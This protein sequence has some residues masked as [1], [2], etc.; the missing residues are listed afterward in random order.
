MGLGKNYKKVEVRI[1]GRKKLVSHIVWEENNPREII[2]FCDVI[3]HIDG[4]PEKNEIKNLKKMSRSSHVKYHHE[5]NKQK[6]IIAS[7]H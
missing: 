3:H 7:Y 1:D 4:N 6:V 2:G 5:L